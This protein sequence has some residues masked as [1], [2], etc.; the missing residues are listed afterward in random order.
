M[1]KIVLKAIGLYQQALSNRKGSQ[2]LEYVFLIAGVI[3]VAGLLGAAIKQG[4]LA[5]DIADK[6]SKYLSES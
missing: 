2:T 5:G 4:D 3:A 6:I 1:E